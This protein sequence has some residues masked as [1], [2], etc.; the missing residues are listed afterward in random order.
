MVFSHKCVFGY[1]RLIAACI[2][3]I[4]LI[5]RCRTVLSRHSHSVGFVTPCMELNE[6]TLRFWRSGKLV[7]EAGN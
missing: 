1:D 3:V 2:N 7:N 6:R 4:A 5:P